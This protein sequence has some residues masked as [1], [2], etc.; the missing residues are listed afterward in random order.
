[1]TCNWQSENKRSLQFHLNFLLCLTKKRK[2]SYKA[3]LKEL[4]ERT[5]VYNYVNI[6]YFSALFPFSFCAS[7]FSCL[8][9]CAA[10]ITERR[11]IKGRRS[12]TQKK[13]KKIKGDEIEMK[14]SKN[15]DIPSIKKKI[16]YTRYSLG[17]SLCA[18]CA[19]IYQTIKIKES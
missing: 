2:E 19:E 1:M 9:L 5:L 14:L 4:K 10:A 15:Y 6:L 11:A 7:S 3:S 18:G 13:K 8:C 12:E 16:N 17:I